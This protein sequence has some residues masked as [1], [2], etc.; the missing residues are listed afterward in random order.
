M[1]MKTFF[2]LMVVLAVGVSACGDHSFYPI[3]DITITVDSDSLVADGST[4]TTIT[5]AANP[6]E[7]PFAPGEQCHL[8]VSNGKL[9]PLGGSWE[10]ATDSVVLSHSDYEWKALLKIS[11]AP[12][13][14]VII[15]ARVNRI[16]KTK[17][18]IYGRVNPTELQLTADA[19]TFNLSS[20]SE[21]NL[22]A[23][24]FR[25][26]NTISANTRVDFSTNL[27]ADNDLR[28]FISLGQ[29]STAANN[30]AIS[31]LKLTGIPDSATVADAPTI[32]RLYAEVFGLDPA[33]SV[34]DSLDILILR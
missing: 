13:D 14:K 32:I 19:Q 10:E 29:T 6:D 27:P 22:K 3:K 33:S 4:V 30:E 12:D 11:A 21:L 25:S 23:L 8:K 26:G 2:P 24:L 17:E 20:V 1:M 7:K 16:V 5:I 9:I 15:T 28:F 34:K 31:T 18:V